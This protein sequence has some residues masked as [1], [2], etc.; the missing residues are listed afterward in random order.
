MP[1]LS[2]HCPWLTQGQRWLLVGAGAIVVILF[3]LG[4]EPRFEGFTVR[5]LLRRAG[6]DPAAAQILV[7]AGDRAVPSLTR[8]L[9]SREPWFSRALSS[10]APFLPERLRR[11]L[12]ARIDPLPGQLMAIEILNQQG[13][14]AAAAL[15]ELIRALGHPDVRV[16]DRAASA[17]AK[18]E[19]ASA[20]VPLTRLLTNQSEFLRVVG[21][22]ALGKIT[23]KPEIAVPAIVQRLQD[24]EPAV[25]NA[26][27]WA[28]WRYG[29]LG[30]GAYTA[31]LPSCR[32]RTHPFAARPTMP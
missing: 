7:R 12:P 31:L 14:H 24:Q 9:A 16:V 18:L 6:Q 28:L 22:T 11:H 19:A 27:A 26:A 10:V 21:L 30:A 32:I 1:A 8:L 2:T 13:T 29:P 20:V 25:K 3:C 17:L 23:V 15:P 4:T 5:Q